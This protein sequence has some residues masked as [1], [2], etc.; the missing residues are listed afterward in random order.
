MGTAIQDF[1]FSAIVFLLRFGLFLV[2]LELAL[3][4]DMPEHCHKVMDVAENLKNT[5]EEQANKAVLKKLL[6]ERNLLRSRRDKYI[7]FVKET[8][9]PDEYLETIKKITGMEV[10]FREVIIK[11]AD[12]TEK[13]VPPHVNETSD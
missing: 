6:E 1:V 10:E 4:T 8:D 7:E 11:I 9:D 12:V 5:K 3:R 2:L 13:L